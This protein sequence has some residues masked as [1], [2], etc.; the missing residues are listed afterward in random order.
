MF[1]WLTRITNLAS[2]SFGYKL[3]EICKLTSTITENHIFPHIFW[4]HHTTATYVGYKY[5]FSW[6]RNVIRII[7]M[8]KGQYFT[9]VP[10]M[11]TKCIF[12][13]R[14]YQL[15]SSTF[16]V[17]ILFSSIF[18][19]LYVFFLKKYLVLLHTYLLFWFNI[20]LNILVDNFFK[21]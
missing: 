20:F 13:K 9:H 7:P 5:R 14:S 16:H 8:P 12:F 1:K 2:L 4:S 19:M 17:S 21:F 15:Y 10:Y 18:V 3:H 11:V 6:S